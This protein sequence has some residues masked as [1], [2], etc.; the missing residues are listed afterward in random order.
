L[1]VESG[2]RALLEGVVGGLR[3]AW[4]LDIPI[5]VAT[6]YSTPPRGFSPSHTRIYRPNEARRF[7]P[8]FRLLRQLARNRYSH[9]G[10]VCSG[11]P[12]LMKWKC[13]L[14]LA[15]PSK[16]FV[17]NE[18]CDYFWLD[19]KHLSAVRQFAITRAGLSGTGAVRTPA[20]LAAFPFTL[21]WLALYAA[22]VHTRRVFRMGWRRATMQE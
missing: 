17:I 15:L 6:C 22:A 8:R 14:A 13:L 5:D 1:L 12:I 7:V 21:A 2:S 9:L 19:R 4:G 16:V 20:R 18:N 11:E 10:I 3:D